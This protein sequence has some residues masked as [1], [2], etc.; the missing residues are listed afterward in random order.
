M[1]QVSKKYSKYAKE[2]KHELDLHEKTYEQYTGLKKK[3]MMVDHK[4]KDVAQ[5]C[6]TLKVE[7][8]ESEKTLR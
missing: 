5:R 4:I 3:I 1:K 6:T 2:F 7:K 8:E